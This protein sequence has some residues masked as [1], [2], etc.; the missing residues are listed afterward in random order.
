[1]NQANGHSVSRAANIE[2]RLCELETRLTFQEE[3]LQE[4]NTLV[5]AQ[6]SE[7]TGLQKQLIHAYKK[8]KSIEADHD[9]GLEDDEAPPH[10]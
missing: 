7:I 10:Y 1:M 5:A 8:I 9:Q 3:H 6:S 4:L 2:D